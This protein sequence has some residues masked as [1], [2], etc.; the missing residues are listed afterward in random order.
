MVEE[1]LLMSR[2]C[3]SAPTSL[4]EEKLPKLKMKNQMQ[5]YSLAPTKVMVEE[6]LLTL[7]L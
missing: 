5:V 7:S 3:S 1:K 4:V 6:K 2:K